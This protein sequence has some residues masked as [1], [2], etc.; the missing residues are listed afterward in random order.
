MIEV[1]LAIDL[2]LAGRGSLTL[3]SEPKKHSLALFV[4]FDRAGWLE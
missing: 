2:E 1:S 3:S 4:A